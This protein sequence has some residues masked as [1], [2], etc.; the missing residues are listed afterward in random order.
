MKKILFLTFF[1]SVLLTSFAQ[2][3][4]IVPDLLPYDDIKTKLFR[5]K[6]IEF[7]DKS[8][9]DLITLFKN[10]ASTSFV[11]LK[12]VTVSETDNQIVLNYITKTETYFRLMGVKNSYY[13]DWYVRLVAQFKDGK[14]RIQFYDDGNVFKPSQYAGYPSTPSRNFYVSSFITKPESVKELHKSLN[15]WYDLHCQWQQNILV[16]VSSCE[17]GIKDTKLIAKNDDF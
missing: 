12:E 15:M 4:E 17:K 13:M 9:K 6:V 8:Q 1:T 10:W 16:T 3:S 11:N 2:N 14:I 5:S 7:P